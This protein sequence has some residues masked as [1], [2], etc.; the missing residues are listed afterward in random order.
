VLPP[1]CRLLYDPPSVL[2]PLSRS[3]PLCCPARRPPVSVPPR[4]CFLAPNVT[5]AFFVF[6]LCWPVPVQ[7][8]SGQEGGRNKRGE[9]HAPARHA[10]SWTPSQGATGRRTAQYPRS[11][12][13]APLLSAT[14]GKRKDTT[15]D[16]RKTWADTQK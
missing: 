16:T 8:G 7:G 1:L 5:M 9:H 6:W 15:H 12:G 10:H 14:G 4:R 2:C 13:F 3:L 11:C